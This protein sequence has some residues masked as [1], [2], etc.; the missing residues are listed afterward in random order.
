[1]QAV[2]TLRQIATLKSRF[3][4]LHLLRDPLKFFQS[5]GQNGA[6]LTEMNLGGRRFCIVNDPELIRDIFVTRGSQFEKFPQGN[7]KQKLFGR[8]LLTSEGTAQK[9]QR[10]ILLPAFH[11][12]R[13]QIYAA[14][15]VSLAENMCRSWQSGQSVDIA[16]FM[17]TLTLRVIGLTF[18]GIDDPRLLADLGRHL[19]TML[20]LVNR[21]VMPWG[22]MLM[23]LPL[24][25]SLRYHSA[26]RQLEQIIAE[27][28]AKAKTT[29]EDNLLRVLVEARKPDG[30]ALTDEEIR[31]EIVTM[32]VA[33]HET[34]AVGLT[35]CLHLL[36]THP[37]LQTSLAQRTT[38]I[39]GSHP[40]GIQHYT[41]LEFLQHAFSESLR[42]YPPIWIMGRRALEPYSSDEFNTP[43]GTIFLVCMA[44]LHRHAEFFP[45]ASAFVPDRWLNPTWP[46]YA[47][48]PFGAGDRRCI[49]ERFAWMEGVFFLACLLR[50]WEFK[51]SG[52]Q[53]EALPQLTLHPKGAVMLEVLERKVSVE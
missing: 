9:S 23:R 33:G 50:R 16:S 1:M 31:D 53:P 8:G 10:R 32:I 3:T 36:A 39:L 46:A 20:H 12:E 28:I 41:D 45:D 11:R 51:S 35:W 48:I 18:F 13:L 17:N 34:V 2:K 6:A 25:S 4:F 52:N 21:F 42:L 24:P 37:S 29:S 19:A 30:S 7:P 47:Y 26:S 22:D 40:P 38:A 44:S 27:L 14:H 5:I 49:G 43:A 15:M